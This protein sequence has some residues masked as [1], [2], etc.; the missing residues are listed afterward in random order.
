[1]VEVV[2]DLLKAGGLKTVGFVNDEQLGPS[3]GTGLGMDVG[4]DDAV[5]GEIDGEGDALTCSWQALVYL[6]R[7]GHDRGS[8]KRSAGLE[9]TF[10]HRAEGVGEKGFP[11][12]PVI[13]T[14][15]V[16]GRKCLADPRRP[17]AQANIA[18]S[19]HRV[20]ELGEAAMLMSRLERWQI[21]PWRGAGIDLP[22]IAEKKSAS[23]IALAEETVFRVSRWHRD[24]I[25][26][27]AGLRR[28]R[29]VPLR[30]VQA[31]HNGCQSA[32]RRR[33]CGGG[34]AVA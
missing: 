14:G 27:V 23:I 13:D 26:V 5:L 20:S 3:A 29:P 18:M 8:E 31:R 28:R 32:A 1:M 9:N 11:L 30:L 22:E 24:A 16:P 34:A 15:I 12:F 33:G 4:V 25:R 10:R 7:G 6:F 17:P 21:G 2:T 19:A